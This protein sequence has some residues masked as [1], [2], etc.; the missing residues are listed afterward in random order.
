M[1][2]HVADDMVNP[3]LFKAITLRAIPFKVVGRGGGGGSGK[4]RTKP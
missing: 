2:L 3:G 1:P 4:N